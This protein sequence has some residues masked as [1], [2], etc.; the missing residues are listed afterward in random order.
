MK[1]LSI[2]LAALIGAA[3][4]P[5]AMAD[6]S[7]D[8]PIRRT[9]VIRHVSVK[10]VLPRRVVVSRTLAV[11]RGELDGAAV[12]SHKVMSRDYAYPQLS[13]GL[14]PT[15]VAVAYD[16]FYVPD[17]GFAYRLAPPVSGAATCVPAPALLYDTSGRFFGYGE[18]QRC[19]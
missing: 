12:Y 4:V 7:D 1:H 13:P 16:Y 8:V 18:G 5:P 3:A 11:P 9:R 10:H 19:Y 2:F 15:P 6:E 14:L 17:Y